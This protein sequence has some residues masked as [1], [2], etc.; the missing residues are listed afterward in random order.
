MLAKWGRRRLQQP[1]RE[2]TGCSVLQL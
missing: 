2:H 1:G